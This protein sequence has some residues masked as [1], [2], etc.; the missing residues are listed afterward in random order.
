MITEYCRNHECHK[1]KSSLVI[2]VLGEEKFFTTN[3]TRNHRGISWQHVLKIYERKR[4][5]TTA[6]HICGHVS[7]LGYHPVTIATFPTNVRR[8]LGSRMHALNAYYD[9]L[10]CCHS[11]Q[12]TIKERDSPRQ[13]TV[14]FPRPLMVRLSICN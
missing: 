9:I 4:L 7:P 8:S 5:L 1:K 6:I 2:A 3:I 13:Q 11:S 12:C 14:P 10:Q